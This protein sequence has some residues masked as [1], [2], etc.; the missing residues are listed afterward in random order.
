[1]IE[2]IVRL[3]V[4]NIILNQ[5]ASDLVITGLLELN[6]RSI[7]AVEPSSVEVAFTPQTAG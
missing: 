7:L 1:M 5:H 3:L 6:G 4:F 2:S